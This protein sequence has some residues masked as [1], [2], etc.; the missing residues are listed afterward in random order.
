MITATVS[1][2]HRHSHRGVE[3]FQ[4]G[5]LDSILHVQDVADDAWHN[6]KTESKSQHSC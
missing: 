5:A 4:A 3:H 1:N 2:L 6:Y